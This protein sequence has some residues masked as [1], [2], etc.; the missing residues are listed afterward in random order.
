MVEVG[1]MEQMSFLVPIYTLVNYLFL[2]SD[3]QGSTLQV[4]TPTIEHSTESLPSI[5]Y[6]QNLFLYDL[7]CAVYYA[8]RHCPTCICVTLLF[9][10]Q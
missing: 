8:G 2:L 10:A 5:F 6:P 3:G 1:V 9:I 4:L 7:F